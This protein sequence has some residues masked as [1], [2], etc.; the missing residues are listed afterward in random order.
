MDRSVTGLSSIGSPGGGKSPSSG[1]SSVVGVDQTARSAKKLRKIAEDSF[2]FASEQKRHVIKGKNHHQQL[3]SK[4]RQNVEQDLK[5]TKQQI[6]RHVLYS[7]AL[8]R[9]QTQIDIVQDA[10]H[11]HLIEKSDP[12]LWKTIQ[13]R[14]LALKQDFSVP[15]DDTLVNRLNHRIGWIYPGL[16]VVLVEASLKYKDEEFSKA[17]E[18]IPIAPM[19]INRELYLTIANRTTRGLIS[20]FEASLL[21]DAVE[22]KI[23]LE[24]IHDAQNLENTSEISDEIYNDRWF[25]LKNILRK[26]IFRL[27]LAR[28]AHEYIGD[29]EDKL[30]QKTA[31]FFPTAESTSIGTTS[32]ASLASGLSEPATVADSTLSPNN[33][34]LFTKSL[35]SLPSLQPSGSLTSPNHTISSKSKAKSNSKGGSIATYGVAPKKEKLS[36]REKLQQELNV[37][38]AKQAELQGKIT[39]D[40]AKLFQEGM[41]SAP[42]STASVTANTTAPSTAPSSS[43]TMSL[44]S[45]STSATKLQSPA[46][47]LYFKQNAIQKLV[48]A[49]EKYVRNIILL[50]LQHW[51]RISFAIDLEWKCCLFTQ[52]IACARI[53][54]A[55]TWNYLRRLSEAW[56]Q[57]KRFV[58]IFEEREKFAAAVDIQRHYRGFI[59]RR[60][61]KRVIDGNAANVIQGIMRIFIAKRLVKK[62]RHRVLLKKSVRKI[63]NLWKKNTWKRALKKAFDQQRKQRAIQLIQRIYRGHRG[64]QR[65]MKYLIR[66]KKKIAATKFQCLWRRYRA[67]I[68]VDK[69]SR[70]RK[71]RRA[72]IVIQAMVRGKLKRLK[73]AVKWDRQCKA[74][75]LQYA[76]LCYKAR[77]ETMRRRRKRAAINIQRVA[78]GMIARRR[79]KALRAKR[80]AAIR[81][82]EPLGK[83]YITRRRIKGPMAKHL[84]K[85]SKAA[86][87]IQILLKAFH[88]GR[89][90]RSRVA[91]IHRNRKESKERLHAIITIQR[92]MRGKLARK[93]VAK[94][95]EDL[96]L[97]EQEALSNK[98]NRPLP[99]YYRLQKSYWQH[100]NM[101]HRKHAIKIQCFVRRFLARRRVHRI[102]VEQSVKKIQY[103][104]KSAKLIEEAKELRR[105]LSQQASRKQS[106]QMA[107]ISNIQRLVRGFITRRRVGKLRAAETIKWAIMEFRVAAKTRR[108]I[109]T[110]RWVVI[111]ILQ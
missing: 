82:I 33:K 74:K 38:M 85:R 30:K 53:F 31:F 109:A 55:L 26:K 81:K 71:R 103:F 69:L 25:M 67:V 2:S 61:A 8:E 22:K 49:M 3:I 111:D 66:R 18:A 48:V 29:M 6:I 7:R 37:S 36:L 98:L 75:I 27:Y 43:A 73:F 4:Y 92:V 105:I 13:L 88:L 76:W 59:A 86:C 11:S 72:A 10:L 101:Y 94:I 97:R 65:F 93:R 91:L 5:N 51:K 64:R 87:K 100:Q 62:I 106:M 35:T 23:P 77:K 14:K 104:Y 99:Y 16:I 39:A 44:G 52:N 20:D 89:Q 17:L 63:E 108:A 90:A 12:A 58:R 45:T 15:L 54:R 96:L 79:V 21:F 83:G 80:Q 42:S 70:Q 78:R 102:R 9:A 32:V 95:R 46:V 40:L 28:K 19:Q 107:S 50:R 1:N 41:T 56:E 68:R 60:L 110:F 84:E 24:K 34:S 47:A 57:M